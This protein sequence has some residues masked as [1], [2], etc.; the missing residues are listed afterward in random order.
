[1]DN[2]NIPTRLGAIVLVIIAIT[3]GIYLYHFEKD[4]WREI[5]TSSEIQPPRNEKPKNGGAACTQEAKLCPDGSS[6]SRTG[7]DCEFAPCPGEN[8]MVGNDKDEHGCIGSAGYSWC[9]G[10]QKCLREWEES[11]NSVDISK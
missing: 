7:T 2:K 3:F 4:K 1:M 11:C 8:G 10:K 6:V 9:E 5:D